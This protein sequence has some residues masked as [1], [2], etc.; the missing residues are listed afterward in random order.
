MTLI[1]VVSITLVAGPAPD[2]VYKNF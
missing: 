1:V 2:I